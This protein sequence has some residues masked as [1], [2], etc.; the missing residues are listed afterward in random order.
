MMNI[1]LDD[2]PIQSLSSG[3]TAFS[4]TASAYSGSIVEGYVNNYKFLLESNFGV[5]VAEARLITWNELTESNIL[6]YA[7]GEFSD[8]YSWVYSTN[9][10]TGSV[11]M[12]SR[13]FAVDIVG[14]I[15]NPNYT[16]NYYGV[17]PVIVVPKYAITGEIVPQ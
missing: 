6:G 7:D 11:G 4:N 17:R 2:N 5:E 1:T 15:K 10:W 12:G 14:T 8:D 13:P 16:S 9:Y 3:T